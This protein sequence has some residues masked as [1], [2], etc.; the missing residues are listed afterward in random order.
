MR[1]IRFRNAFFRGWFAARAQRRS[2]PC[3]NSSELAYVESGYKAGVVSGGRALPMI[4]HHRPPALADLRDDPSH[5]QRK[6]PVDASAQADWV[7]VELI[8][9]ADDVPLLSDR[10]DKHE[11]ADDDLPVSTEDRDSENEGPAL[12]QKPRGHS[13]FWQD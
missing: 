13:R 11:G 1:R 5:G 12:K 10:A 7:D 2:P 3:D 9:N 4:G 8:A 6:Q